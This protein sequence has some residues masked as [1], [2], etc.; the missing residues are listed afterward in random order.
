MHLNERDLLDMMLGEQDFKLQKIK[1]EFNEVNQQMESLTCSMLIN[2]IESHKSRSRSLAEGYFFKLNN[3]GKQDLVF[4]VEQS[5]VYL[6]PCESVKRI[7]INNITSNATCY[8]DIPVL[9]EKADGKTETGFL[10]DN[11][12]IR[13]VSSKIDCN[14]KPSRSVYLNS[15]FNLLDNKFNKVV[16]S[17][18][19]ITAALPF[20]IANATLNL[21]QLDQLFDHHDIIR[22]GADVIDEINSIIE[23]KEG[24]NSFFIRDDPAR[25]YMD[26]TERKNSA[27]EILNDLSSKTSGFFGSIGSFF[28]SIFSFFS[29]AFL[30]FLLVIISLVV[31]KFVAK[32][33]G[34]SDLKK[35]L[36]E[37]IGRKQ[38]A[39]IPLE[40]II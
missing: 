14:L 9:Y 36:N 35:K 34:L 13:K 27:R 37:L 21:T 2:S 26:D 15:S 6:P 29:Y 17:R 20:Q 32:H 24:D 38:F 1:S 22:D 10:L 30:L 25:E 19:S 18:V 31:Y 8:R 33:K 28:S 7:F 16:L 39:E 5:R 4:F 3:L 40:D 11:M 23:Q 12:I